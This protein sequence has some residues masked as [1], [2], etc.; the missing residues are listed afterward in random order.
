MSLEQFSQPIQAE[1]LE[2][3][4][5]L[6]TSKL[7]KVQFTYVDRIAKGEIE[8]I[9]ASEK[10][11]PIEELMRR[12]TSL[13]QYVT[14][15]VYAKRKYPLKPDE[16]D[17]LL[18]DLVVTLSQLHDEKPETWTDEVPGIIEYKVTSFISNNPEESDE[19][20]KY[21]IRHGG[22]REVQKAGL[23]GYEL[24]L[25]G[26]RFQNVPGVSKVDKVIR[27]HF[28]EFY[29][30]KSQSDG[31]KIENIF[32]SKSF[33]KLAVAIVEKYPEV[34]LLTG[35]S[36]LLDTPIAKRIGFTITKRETES[37]TGYAFWLQF[38]DS[39]GQINTERI[40]QL[41]ETGKPP[42]VEATG[43]ISVIDFLKKYLPDQKRGTV[44]LKELDPASLAQREND[45]R[46]ITDLK[47]NWDSLNEAGIKKLFADFAFLN[48]YS[49]IPLTSDF[50]PTV[51]EYKAAGKSMEE[52]ESSEKL[53]WLA[54]LYLSYMSTGKYIEKEYQI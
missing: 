16:H 47:K 34:K 5:Q 17:A 50:L 51:L 36:W 14:D 3:H 33:E 39:S 45:A 11:K 32:S 35:S 7:Q 46:I 8:P 37:H 18:D 26:E 41:L 29:K 6:L 25:S 13:N 54:P 1:N 31:E 40:K 15:A 21:A 30:Q 22:D 28:T 4:E 2:N 52:L 38:I 48:E 24:S 49:N 27:L 20:M 53:A 10:G 12:Y 9:D 23:I 44:T 43:Y 19:K 42:Y